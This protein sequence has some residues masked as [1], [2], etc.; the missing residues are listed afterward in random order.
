MQYGN[1]K[2]KLKCKLG[3][4]DYWDLDFKADQCYFCDHWEVTSE[5]RILDMYL[6]IDNWLESF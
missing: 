2:R 5:V 3:F 6:R 4:H 1:W